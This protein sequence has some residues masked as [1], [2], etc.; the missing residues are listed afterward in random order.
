MDVAANILLGALVMG[1]FIAGLFFLRYWKRTGDRFF[2][3]FAAS[4]VLGAITRLI[5]D[6]NVPPAGTEALGYALRV[7]QYLTI[8]VAIVDKNRVPVRG[9]IGIPVVSER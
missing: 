1:E 7:V 5:I 4:F 6:D 8:I 9:R 3:F 2:L